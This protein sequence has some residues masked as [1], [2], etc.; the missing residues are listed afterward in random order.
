MYREYHKPDFTPSRS[1][2]T[3]RIRETVT[4][5]L[6]TETV[7]LTE[8]A[9]RVCAEDLYARNTLPNRPVSRMDG[10]AVRFEDFGEGMPDTSLWQEGEQYVFSNTGTA[11][12]DGYDTVILIEEVSF[13]EGCLKL[14]KLPK[15]QGENISPC[16]GLMKEGELLA[17]RGEMITPELA[18]VL[19]A[20]GI[21]GV[22]VLSRPKVAVL[23]TG[24]ELVPW[25]VEVPEGKNVETNSLMLAGFIREWGGQAHV[26]PI[27]P[28]DPQCLEEALKRAAAT[29]DLVVLNAGS[30]KGSKDYSVDVMEKIGDVLVY[31][32]GHG[33]GKHSSL[34]LVDGTPV[35]G[36][37]GP[38]AGAAV[39]ARLYLRAAMDALLLQP[40]EIMPSVYAVLDQDIGGYPVDFCARIHLYLDGSRY[41]AAVVDRCQTR[42][43]SVHVINGYLYL[44]KGTSY[45]A[46]MAVLVELLYPLSRIT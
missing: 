2:M 42:A 12:P 19:A 4:S 3:A 45:Q 31:E 24:D 9:G 28:D 5:R 41:R 26:F 30:S 43:E 33:P 8:C 46:G 14:G 38:P 40:T 23:P 44:P 22:P 21:R 13:P 25:D 32:L 1:E 34:S 15:K 39:A 18:G 36:V 17:A 29:A 37:A 7:G 16:G 11:V 20:G 6:W 10:I 35:L 27:I